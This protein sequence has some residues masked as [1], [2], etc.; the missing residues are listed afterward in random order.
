MNDG[1]DVCDDD[2]D[3]ETT[4]EVEKAVRRGIATSSS[5]WK[6]PACCFLPIETALWSW[7]GKSDEPWRDKPNM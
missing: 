3:G 2:D 4:N 1:M 5:R 6:A 7:Y